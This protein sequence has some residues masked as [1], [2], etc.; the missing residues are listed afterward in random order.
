MTSSVL[1]LAVDECESTPCGS[2]GDCEDGN[3]QYVCHCHDGYGGSHCDIGKFLINFK[4]LCIINYYFIN[5]VI[6][7]AI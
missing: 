1:V 3:D 4:V 2:H 7:H 6:F 5:M